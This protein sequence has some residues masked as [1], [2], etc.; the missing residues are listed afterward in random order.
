MRATLTASRGTSGTGSTPR[1]EIGR[2]HWTAFFRFGAKRLEPALAAS[3]SNNGWTTRR[4]LQQWPVL[5]ATQGVLPQACGTRCANQISAERFHWSTRVVQPPDLTR[6]AAGIG[7]L[8]C[9]TDLTPR[10][11]PPH[12][13]FRA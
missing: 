5:R 9:S 4:M 7:A 12:L 13:R 3:S 8:T 10:S 6:R 2:R 11:A 1:G